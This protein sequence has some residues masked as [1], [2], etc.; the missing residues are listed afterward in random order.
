MTREGTEGEEGEEGVVS[1]W[2]AGHLSLKLDAKLCFPLIVHLV[3]EIDYRGPCRSVDVLL[4][5]GIDA[6]VPLNLLNRIESTQGTTEGSE[7]A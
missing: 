6:A 2:I 1:G 4:P 5:A 7:T 3:V